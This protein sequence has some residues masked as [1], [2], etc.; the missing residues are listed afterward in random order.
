M[1]ENTFEVEAER[2][3]SAGHHSIALSLYLRAWSSPDDEV[4]ERILDLVEDW[5]DTDAA[6]ELVSAA[7]A[8]GNAGAYEALGDLLIQLRRPEEAVS[9][10]QE[11]AR[12]GRDVTLWIAGVLADEIGDRP[13]A[14]EYYRQALAENKPNALNDYGAFL[15]DDGERLDEAAGLL[16]QAVDQGDTMAAGNLGRLLMDE[17]KPAEAIPWLRQALDAGHRSVLIALGEAENA[18]GDTEAAG[19]RLREAL[20]EELP[21]AHFAY[22]LHLADSNAC[23]EAIPHYE[24]ALDKDGE[25]N[26][27]LNLALLHEELQEPVQADRRYQDAIAHGDE[28]AFLPYAHFLAR[29]GRVE[30]I[31]ALLAQASSL[32]LD[33]EELSELQALASKGHPA[34]A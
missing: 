33:P 29:Q 19:R 9:A 13:R 24:A 30:Q 2:Q 25:T 18:T 16:R 15:S 27:Y 4:A 28:D 21:G 14:E 6:L 22:A 20:A 3:W 26:A 7:A 8:A 23:Q 32:D 12:S 10:L 5:G 31:V 1:P 34:G 11:A 17:D